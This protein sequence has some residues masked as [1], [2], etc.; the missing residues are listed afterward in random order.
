MR[1]LTIYNDPVTRGT[2]TEPWVYWDE[3]FNNDEL[4]KI[5]EYLIEVI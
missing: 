4:K 5:T 3:R 2:V 1:T